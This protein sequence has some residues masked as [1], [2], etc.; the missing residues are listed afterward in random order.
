MSL[1]IFNKRNYQSS[2]IVKGI[3]RIPS[4]QANLFL[5]MGVLLGGSLLLISLF[6][7]LAE[8]END[9][10]LVFFVLLVVGTFMLNLGMSVPYLVHLSKE[11]VKIKES[12][13]DECK[14]K[15]ADKD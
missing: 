9:D 3:S 15:M 2:T 5:I 7:C 4:S 14:A 8:T 10:A 6:A 12:L 1:G 13:C 11:V